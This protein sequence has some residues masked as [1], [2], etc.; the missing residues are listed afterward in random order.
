MTFKNDVVKTVEIVVIL[1][2]QI[3]ALSISFAVPCSVQCIHYLDEG[4]L[5]LITHSF[6]F[7]DDVYT[8]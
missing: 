5:W 3:S 8:V 2:Q 7:E 1:K 4:Y 6:I